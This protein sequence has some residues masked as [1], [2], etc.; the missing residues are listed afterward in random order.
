MTKRI[1]RTHLNSLIPDKKYHDVRWGDEMT[2]VKKMTGKE[3]N[4]RKLPCGYI[5]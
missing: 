1:N 4:G 5:I 2:V 3:E